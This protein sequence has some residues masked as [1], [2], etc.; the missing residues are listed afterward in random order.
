MEE[1]KSGKNK[2]KSDFEIYVHHIWSEVQ[3]FKSAQKLSRVSR[4][5]ELRRKEIVIKYRIIQNLKR[6]FYAFPPMKNIGAP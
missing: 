6:D 4:V 2:M 5:T 3:K 1:V